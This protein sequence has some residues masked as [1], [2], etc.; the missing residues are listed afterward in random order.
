M[1]LW[2]PVIV[3]TTMPLCSA[4]ADNR[5]IGASEQLA[6]LFMQSCVR[7]AGNAPGLSRWIDEIKLPALPPPGQQAFL[8]GRRGIAYDATNPEGKFVILS[9]EDG[10][11][12]AIVDRADSAA[13]V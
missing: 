12:S 8:K 3:A 1:N 7:F 11:C 5:T 6:G 10:S 2:L 9:G 13:L 4:L